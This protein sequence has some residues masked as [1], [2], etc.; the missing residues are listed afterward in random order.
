MTTYNWKITN[1][2]TKTVEGLQDYVVTAMF[3]VEG[4]DGEFSNTVN[5]SQMFTVKEGAEFVPYANLTEE[6]VVEWIKEELGG[7]GLLSITACIDGQIE[8]QKNPPVVAVISPL[9]WA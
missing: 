7:N 5:G 3:E 6:I 8:S 4:V 2:Y 1:L 9:P